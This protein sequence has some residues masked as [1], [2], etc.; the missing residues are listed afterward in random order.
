MKRLLGVL[1]VSVASSAWAGKFEIIG[2]GTATKAAE[3][4]NID[5]QIQSE[6]HTSALAARKSADDLTDQALIALDKFKAN[7]PEQ[8]QVSPGANAQAQKIIY[9]NN[10][11]VIVC[12]ENHSWTSSTTVRF[13]LDNLQNLAA[14]QDSLLKLNVVHPPANAVNVA[15]LSLS[16]GRPNPG[17]F[18]NTWD[19][20]SDLALQRSQQNALRQVLVLTQGTSQSNIELLKVTAAKD[21]SGQVLYDRIDTEGDTGGIGLGHVSVKIARQFTY[22]VGP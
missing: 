13:R 19:D 6:C 11:S 14:L 10:Q 2:E 20:M 1:I 18:A 21:V 7:I 8:L 16:L 15:R 12:D 22:K 4:I 5:I 9:V 3:F 17:V